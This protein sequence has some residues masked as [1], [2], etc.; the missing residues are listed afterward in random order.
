MRVISAIRSPFLKYDILRVSFTSNYTLII[1]FK[2]EK[3]SRWLRI[4]RISESALFPIQLARRNYRLCHFLLIIIL[5]N[6]YRVHTRY[7][8]RV[9]S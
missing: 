5:C 8:H 4:L 2:L 1:N 9:L 7:Y 3:K 6:H